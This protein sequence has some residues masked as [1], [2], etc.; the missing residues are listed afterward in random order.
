MG[1][2]ISS[3]FDV[4]IVPIL[5]NRDLKLFTEGRVDNMLWQYHSVTEEILVC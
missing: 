3:A 4:H 1:P 5:S 2:G